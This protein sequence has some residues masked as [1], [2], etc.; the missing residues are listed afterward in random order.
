MQTSVEKAKKAIQ[1]TLPH[2]T[3]QREPTAGVR[4]Y[5]LDALRGFDMFWIMGAEELF[6]GMAKA[7]G[8]RF[9]EAMSN[10]F[11]HPSWNGFHIYDLI[12]PLFLFLAGVS[13]PYSVGRELEKGTSKKRLIVRIVKR[14]IILVLLGMVYNNGLQIRPLAEFRISS[15]LGRIG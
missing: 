14:G 12:F 13:T 15:V 1:V 8:N 7:T 6:H 4:L 11:T 5:S 2:D 10:Q 3:L 9:W